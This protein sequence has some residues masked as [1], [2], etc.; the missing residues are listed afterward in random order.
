MLLQFVPPPPTPF[1]PYSDKPSS[2]LAANSLAPH[3]EQKLQ[4]NIA[5]F[6]KLAARAPLAAS[7]ALEIGDMILK[8]FGA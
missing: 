6:R 4:S 8:N 2:T 1:K 3:L 5:R 7:M